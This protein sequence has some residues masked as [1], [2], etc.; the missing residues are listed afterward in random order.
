M[1]AVYAEEKSNLKVS[2]VLPEFL[3]KH[4]S[5]LGRRYVYNYLLRD[6]N[7]G[8]LYSLFGVLFLIAGL[9]FG[10]PHWIESSINS[11]AATSG[12][13]MLAALPILIGIQFLIAFLHYD[14]SRTPIE[15]LCTTLAGQEME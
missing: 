13:V 7:V 12:T 9:A 3:K 8:S 10:V 2:R 14:V 1:D 5:R 11:Q 6:F 4:L 15:P